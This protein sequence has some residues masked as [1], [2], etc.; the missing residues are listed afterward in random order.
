MNLQLARER[1]IPSRFMFQC[2]SIFFEIVKRHAYNNMTLLAFLKK[3]K[4]N[5][6]DI[7]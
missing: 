6:R 5:Q 1:E 3:F 4:I 2:S 7:I